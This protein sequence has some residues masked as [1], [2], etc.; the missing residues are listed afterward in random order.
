MSQNEQFHQACE[1]WLRGALQLLSNKQIPYQEDMEV[2]FTTNGGYQTCGGI[3][4]VDIGRLYIS[5]HDELMSLPEYETIENIVLQTP[6]LT[7][8]LCMDAGG[9]VHPEIGIQ[10][11]FIERCLLVLLTEYFRTKQ[12]FSFRTADHE[13]IYEKLEQFIYSTEPFDAV[14]LVHIRNLITD[15][16][17]IRLDRGVV[18]RQATHEER[19][20]AVKTLFS[21]FNRSVSSDVPDM[22]LEIHQPA[23]RVTPLDLQAASIIAQSAVLALRLI[24]DN[25]IGLVSYNWDVPEQPFRLNKNGISSP[26][27]LPSAFSGERYILTEEEAT[28]LPRLFKKTKKANKNPKLSIAITRFEDAYTRIKNE[29]KLID[30]WTALEALFLYDE[31]NFQMSRTLALAISYYL[32]KNESERQSI[33]NDITR[34][35]DLRSDVVHGKE[36]KQN[37]NLIEMVTKTENHLRHA[38]RKRIEE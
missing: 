18:L 34:S 17:T 12:D 26:F 36:L 31:S 3:Y 21:P 13:R 29:D 1:Q 30:Y 23:D 14:C 16:N 11:H 32:G 2:T 7:S 20:A 22:F 38:L 6:A 28:I 19:V 25:P 4:I 24:K 35:H 5:Y 9:E 10:R 27:I 33:K 15:V 8:T 37:V